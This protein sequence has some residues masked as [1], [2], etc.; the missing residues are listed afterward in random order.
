MKK[1]SMILFVVILLLANITAFAE[2]INFE[3]VTDIINK[4]DINLNSMYEVEPNDTPEQAERNNPLKANTQWRRGKLSVY[5][6]DT[7][8]YYYYNHLSYGDVTFTVFGVASRQPVNLEIY[9]KTS[10][11]TMKRI[12][13]RNNITFQESIT[14]TDMQRGDY[15]MKITL[16]SGVYQATYDVTIDTK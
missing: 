11:G 12:G 6:G 13:T 15:F 16:P 2:D 3:N 8:D 4:Q 5:D 9:Q 10:S 1:K 7:V 14:L